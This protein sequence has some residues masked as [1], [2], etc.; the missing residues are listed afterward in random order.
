MMLK[1]IKI[2]KNDGG[3]KMKMKNSNNS[4]INM[5]PGIGNALQASL[6]KGPMYNVSI[7]GKR[8]SIPNLSRVH[9]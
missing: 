8:F 6:R 1:K 7:D 9:G 4:L 3:P 2:L 5:E